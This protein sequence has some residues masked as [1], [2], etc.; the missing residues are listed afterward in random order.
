MTPM[1]AQRRQDLERYGSWERMTGGEWFLPSMPE[2]KEEHQRTFRLVK[3]LNELHNTDPERAKGILREILPEDSAVPGLH[4]PLNL[5]YGCNLICGER[6][7]IN[8]GATI[9]AQAQVMLGDGVMVGPNCSLI[10]VG[11][12]VNDHEMRAGG[13]EIALSLIH[14]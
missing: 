13:W 5:E 12:P 3:Q 10:T 8:F 4:V 2:A 1:D 6:V 11:H 14:I 7:F 9:L